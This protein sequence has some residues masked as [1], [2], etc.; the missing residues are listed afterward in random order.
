MQVKSIHCGNTLFI[1]DGDSQTCIDS[2]NKDVQRKLEQG[3]SI[4]HNDGSREFIIYD[5]IRNADDDTYI[6]DKSGNKVKHN[7]VRHIVTKDGTHTTEIVGTS[8]RNF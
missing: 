7:K 6:W 3:N 1:F 4:K 5:A 8:F 2:V